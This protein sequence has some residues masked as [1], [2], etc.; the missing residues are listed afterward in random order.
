MGNQ[1]ELIVVGINTPEKEEFVQDYRDAVL[2]IV[3]LLCERRELDLC[4]NQ[5]YALHILAHTARRITVKPMATDS[6]VRM[7][8]RCKG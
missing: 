3:M 4:E 2:E 6:L 5:L 7:D 8:R 1:N